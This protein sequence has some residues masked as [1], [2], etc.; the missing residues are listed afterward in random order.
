MRVQDNLGELSQCEHF[1]PFTVAR[2]SDRSASAVP[3]VPQTNPARPGTWFRLRVTGGRDVRE[4]TGVLLTAKPRQDH[5]ARPH[6]V[7]HCLYTTLMPRRAR[8]RDDMVYAVGSSAR[9]DS[10]SKKDHATRA[11]LPGPC[12]CRLPCCSLPKL[13]IR[14]PH[15][16]H[17][18]SPLSS[19]TRS[20]SPSSYSLRSHEAPCTGRFMDY[21]TCGM[22]GPRHPTAPVLCA[23]HGKVGQ[24]SWLRTVSSNMV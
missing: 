17:V 10:P 11:W 7:D 4:S 22:A 2:R 1:A 12:C 3:A 8:A 16:S 15:R 23:P 18:L 9:R 24:D 5:S 21:D 19:L 6:R 13:C 20:N 14:S